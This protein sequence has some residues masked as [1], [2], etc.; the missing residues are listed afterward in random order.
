MLF[1]LSAWACPGLLFSVIRVL[2]WPPSRARFD[3]AYR[4]AMEYYAAPTVQ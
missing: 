1:L 3:K 2:A 4:E